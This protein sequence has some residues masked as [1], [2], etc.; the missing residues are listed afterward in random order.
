MTDI[1]AKI[2]TYKR[3]EIAADKA[4]E[5][6]A[7]LQKKAE[8]AAPTRGFLAALKQAKEQ[9]RPSLIAEIKKASPSKGLI[10]ADFVPGEIAKAYAD[11]G[12]DCLSVLTD[13]PSFQGDPAYL[14]EARQACS[15]PVLRKDF[16]YDP[17]QVVQARSWGA[18]AILIILSAVDDETA[19]LLHNVAQDLSMDVLCEVH[20][21]AEM[22]RAL[23]L[24][25][26]LIGINN[27]NLKT[28][29]TTLDTSYQLM[30]NIPDDV[31]LVS[32]SGIFTSKELFAL[33]DAGAHSFLVGES[34]MR[35]DNI[36]E[37]TGRLLT[38]G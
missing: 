27:R 14:A 28:F 33:F 37:A 12:A 11:G 16:M 36:A 5:S 21:A 6:L 2:G 10:R 25:M 31:I 23:K 22:E 7:S 9:S 30:K 1:L 24:N 19:K 20:D 18:D 35:Q 15:L 34:L 29:E 13:K 3:Q 38:R 8:S 26:K 32:E 4:Q 17:Y